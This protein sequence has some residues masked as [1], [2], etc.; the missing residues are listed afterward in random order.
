MCKITGPGQAGPYEAATMS[1]KES[2]N[3]DTFL[4]KITFQISFLC[5]QL[6]FFS[7]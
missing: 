3:V 7:F 1:K 2:W 5:E 4:F 6:D